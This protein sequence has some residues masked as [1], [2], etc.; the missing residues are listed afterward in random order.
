[1][2]EQDFLAVGDNSSG[3]PQALI[4]RRLSQH[5][6]SEVS[7]PFE[8]PLRILLVTARPSGLGFVDPRSV[9][10]E[11]VAEM[12]Q[13]VEAGDIEVEFLRPPTLEKL[14]TRLN[15]RSRPVHVLHFDGHG[16]FDEGQAQQGVLAFENEG[17][18]LHLVKASEVRRVLYRS[19][20]RLAVLTACQSAVSGPDDALSSVA[21]QL[22]QGD[23]CS[24]CR[25]GDECQRLGEY[26]GTLRQSLLPLAG[27]RAFCPGV[28]C[29]SA[30]WLVS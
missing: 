26:C 17:G 12:G 19:G 22:L 16:V 28:P 21:A 11:L 4:V 30:T 15:D 14:R 5:E 24:G 20:V 7:A 3:S 25:G 29:A 8:P 6:L 13:Q 18:G 1:M 9:A 10:R 2:I 27:G 23:G